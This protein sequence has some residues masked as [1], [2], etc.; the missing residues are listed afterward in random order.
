[1]C[2]GVNEVRSHY[3]TVEYTNPETGAGPEREYCATNSTELKATIEQGPDEMWVVVPKGRT[4]SFAV[5]GSILIRQGQTIHLRANNGTTIFNGD[6]KTNF[7]T[8]HGRLIADTLV[9]VNGSSTGKSY[10]W[11][12]PS[13]EMKSS[14]SGGAIHF[15]GGLSSGNLIDCTFLNN[16]YMDTVNHGRDIWN[17]GELVLNYNNF[18]PGWDNAP[19]PVRNDGVL[20]VTPEEVWDDVA[21]FQN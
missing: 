11:T 15:T 3:T 20:R 8:V 1:L 10:S 5:V 4:I 7:F 13:I 19:R 18:A 2:Q 6:H 14:L 16:N 17:E 9:F 21:R 12:S